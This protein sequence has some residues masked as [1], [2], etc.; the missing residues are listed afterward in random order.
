M[1]SICADSRRMFIVL[2]YTTTSHLEN[3]FERE[4]HLPHAAVGRSDTTEIGAAERS[5]RQSPNRVIQDVERFGTELQFVALFDA[6]VLV[7]GEIPVKA[8]APQDRLTP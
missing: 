6:E 1:Q 5:V 3:V 7:G 4:L 2:F 8:P